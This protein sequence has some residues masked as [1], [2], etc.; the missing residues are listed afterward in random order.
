[1]TL[2]LDAT[3][4]GASANS[5]STL[6]EITTAAER[7]LPVPGWAEVNTTRR[8]LVAVMATDLLDRMRF[9]GDRVDETQALEWPRS[10]VWNK[11]E[12]AL[13]DEDA[14]P[15]EVKL[16][17]ARL[18]LWLADQDDTVDPFQA[19]DGAG[20]QSVDFGSEL[21]MT[22]E[23]GA[24]SVPAGERFLADVIRPILGRLVLAN[25][26]KVVRG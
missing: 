6:A 13:L 15:A 22:F 21:S 23:K 17:H 4:G 7:V 24:G 16:A 3:V 10:G 2:T 14:I 1:M 9:I 20:V 8:T 11:R 18:A 12:S 19:E 26:A 25:Q 5:Y